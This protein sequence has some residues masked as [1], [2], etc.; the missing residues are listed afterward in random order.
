[1]WTTVVIG[2]ITLVLIPTIIPLVFKL[3]FRI[4]GLYLFSKTQGRR[5]LLL[6]KALEDGKKLK[7]KFNTWHG[8]VGFF[9][10]FW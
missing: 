6:S 4:L 5:E 1:M 7:G 9:H 10:P 3:C 2:V 8:I